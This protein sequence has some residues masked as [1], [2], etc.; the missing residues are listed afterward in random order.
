MSD[1]N[2]NNFESNVDYT[3][4]LK[5]FEGPLDLLLYLIKSNK[6]EI[7]NI[8][9]SEVTSQYLEYMKGLPALDA[10]KAAEYLVIA[11]T[12]LSI[13][14]KSLVPDE[15]EE[16]YDDDGYYSDSDDYEDDEGAQLIR[17]LEEYK[18]I[19]EETPKLK[20]METVGYFYKEPD[21]GVGKTRIVYKDFTLEKLAQAFGEVLLRMETEAPRKEVKEIKK[22]SFT[23]SEKISYVRQFLN[24]REKA[25]FCELLGNT[26]DKAEAITTFQA[27]LELIKHQFIYVTQDDIYAPIYLTL[28]PERNEEEDFG[29]VDEYN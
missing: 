20:E 27:L 19:Q 14:A 28:N 5:N 21:K 25:E 16:S 18:L 2:V 4:I 11:T 15:E 1:Y 13:K 29:E 8:F 9:V 24:E 22:D 7:R 17:A 26:Y 10:E 23:V 6:I 3:T 12:I